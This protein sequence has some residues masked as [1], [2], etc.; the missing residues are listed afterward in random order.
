MNYLNLTKELFQSIENEDFKRVEEILADNFTFEGPMPD[1]LHKEDFIFSHR[2]ILNAFSDFRYNYSGL[3]EEGHTVS[4]KVS[5]SGKNTGEFDL[6]FVNGPVVR[7][8]N[9][10]VKL[11]EEE[12]AVTVGN[13]KIVRLTVNSPENGGIE[14]MLEQLDIEIPEE[15]MTAREEEEIE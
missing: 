10:T 2:K 7:P 3:K 6:S 11:P 12:F 8:T 14:G 15:Q 4:G 13:D 5:I 9:K 1:I